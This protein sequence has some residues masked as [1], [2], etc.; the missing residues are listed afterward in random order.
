MF[1]WDGSDVTDIISQADIYEAKYN[2]HIYWI[3]R[4]INPET[5]KS[6]KI[7]CI[8][9]NSKNT[10]PCLID[11][12]KTVFRLPKIGSHWCKQGG[13]LRILLRCLLTPEGHIKEELT[14]QMID[15]STPLLKLQVQEIFTFREILGVN[16]SYES[17]IVL[18]EGG[19]GVYPV[20]Y[21]DPSMTI[22]DTKVIPYTILDKWFEEDTNIDEVVKR[23]LRI[24]QL[25]QIG[26]VL[27]EIRTKIDE[28]VERVDR[29]TI[30]Y[31]D[32]IM[33]R[34]TERIQTS[35]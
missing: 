13:K 29:N 22:T 9:R 3:I 20:S 14:L 2:K 10:V 19:G 33:N 30:T 8:V 28:V 26:T 7:T 15:V 5:N 18:R 17:S 16:C 27:Y 35:F 6:E 25:D 34:I 21:Y 12:M 1:N 11:E 24:H 4:V 32:C 23:L 31:K